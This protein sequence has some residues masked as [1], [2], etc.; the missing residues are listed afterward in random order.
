MAKAVLV[1][2]RSPFDLPDE[3]LFLRVADQLTP[4]GITP[5]SPVILSDRCVRLILI[6]PPPELRVSGVSACLGLMLRPSRTGGARFG[7][8]GP[9][10]RPFR[11]DPTRWSW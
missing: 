4:E 2:S 3:A 10:I 11:C 9:D 6:N 5:R 7:R 1:C 8:A